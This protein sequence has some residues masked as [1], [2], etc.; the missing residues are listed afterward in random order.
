MTLSSS[1]TPTMIRKVISLRSGSSFTR[2][3]SGS[4]RYLNPAWQLP[5]TC[6]IVESWTSFS[7]LPA[8]VNSEEKSSVVITTA[9]ISIMYF[10]IL[11][12]IGFIASLFK[13]VLFFT[14]DM[15]YVPFLPDYLLMQKCDRLQSLLSCQPSVLSHHYA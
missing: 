11:V 14:V 4:L 9:M 12:L 6:L 2:S 10:F 5:P 1:T 7:M 15:I 13:A 8:M 3:Y